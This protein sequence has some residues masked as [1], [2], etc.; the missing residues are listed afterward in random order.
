MRS[1]LLLLLLP[2]VALANGRP[3]ATNGV[4]FKPDDANS[5]Y[6]RSTFG[7]LISRDNGCS[8]RWVCEK[9]IGYG[10]EFD[11]KYAVATDGTIFATTFRGLHL[12]R[13]GGCTWSVA[14][15]DQPDGPGKIDDIWIDALDIAPNN[16]LWVATAESAMP[17]DVYRSL[18]N[19]Q[20]F[21]PRNRA[22]AT[23]WYKSVKVARKDPQRV[24]VTGYQVQPTP[25]AHFY[26]SETG[27][28]TWDESPLAGVRFGGT[29]VLFASAVD[30]ENTDTVMMTSQAANGEGDVLYRSID[31]GET[32]TQVLETTAEIRDVLFRPDGTVYVATVTGTF[33]SNDRGAT[34]LPLPGT[35]QLACI[36]QSSDGQLF[37]CGT[38]WDP[39]FKAV[40]K[41]VDATTWDKAFRFVE[42][43]GP[44]EC[45]AGTTAAT[46]CDPMWPALQ[47]QFGATGPACLAPPDATPPPKK[48]G[49]CDAGEG[50]L[51]A[52]ALVGW[53]AF[54]FRRRR[55]SS[56]TRAS[57]R[58]PA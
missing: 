24:Y 3:P 34:F 26:W 47:A 42:L 2:A 50:E 6:V 18:D 35:P 5:I 45:G 49:C 30:P 39:D 32:F 57:R 22:S 36:G 51:G 17:N 8:Y 9:A 11:P 33:R 37:G 16:D 29:P 46:E 1:A 48:A 55:A 56:D 19:G 27:G 14:T 23:V 25:Q 44:L 58:D 12:S 4:F 10:G 38:N 13:D 28:D 43:A 40:A 31:G 54:V 15:A 53:L 20:T 52:F 7:L 21:S 41:S